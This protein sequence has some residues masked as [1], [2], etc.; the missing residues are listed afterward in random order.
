GGGGQTGAATDRHP[1]G[2]LDVRGGGGGTQHRPAHG[3]QR[4]GGERLPGPGQLAV[5]EQPRLA[6]DGDQGAGGVEEVDEQHGEDDHHHL[7]GQDVT[8]VRERFPEGRR[9]A[10]HIGH[11]ATGQ[12]D[13]A[14]DHPGYRGDHHAVEDPATEAADQ[15]QRGHHQPEH[16]QQ[17]LRAAQITQ[18][19]QGFAVGD[20][21][22][23]VP[24]PDEGDE[25]P[26]PGGGGEFQLHR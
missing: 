22:L 6:G 5:L 21:D 17:G 26:D 2:G 16:R 18:G 3:G 24:Q 12:I 8:Q 13:Q 19:D 14:G 23:G 25:Q 11:H 4:V 7:G 20:D 10:R 1:G 15:Q 9:Q